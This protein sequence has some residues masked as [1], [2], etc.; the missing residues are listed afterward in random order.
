MLVSRFTNV[1]A[2][3]VFPLGVGTGAL[4]KAIEAK[5]DTAIGEERRER[6][7]PHHRVDCYLIKLWRY[8]VFNLG[9]DRVSIQSAKNLHR[10][11]Q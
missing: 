10:N 6:T 3:G 9:K 7:G 11:C 5:L 1:T 2:E 8:Q 4:H